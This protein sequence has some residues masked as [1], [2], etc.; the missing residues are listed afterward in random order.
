MVDK[1]RVGVDR[2]S[3]EKLEG[4]WSEIMDVLLASFDTRGLYIHC[5]RQKDRFL[6]RGRTGEK[7]GYR[8][9]KSENIEFA[10]IDRNERLTF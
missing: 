9:I 5:V 8:E 2:M 7:G 3:S 4:G 6:R 10:T 1:L